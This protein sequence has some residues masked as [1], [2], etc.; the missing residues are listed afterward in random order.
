MIEQFITKIRRYEIRIRKAVNAD[1]RGSFRSV[2]KGSGVEFADL[3]E[4]QYGDDVRTIDWNVSAKGHGTFVK[5]FREEKEQTVFFILDVSGSQQVG[6]ANHSKLDTAKE[7]CGVLALSAIQEASH[8]GLLCFS[9][10]KEK[11]IHPSNGMKH[12]YELITELYKLK[13]TSTKTNLAESILF[14]LNVL[15][16]RSVVIFISD[17]I[18]KNYEHNL[19]ALARKHDLVM[20]HLLDKRETNLPRLGII[21]MVDPESNRTIWVNAS[22]P[23]F[24]KR[25][26]ED[27]AQV[28]KKIEQFARQ[29]DINYVAI[30][31]QQD[32]VEPLIKLFRIRRNK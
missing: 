20:V 23:W 14:T 2:F 24:R 9:D 28:G 25:V 19:R 10:Q 17:F 6:H 7:I 13:P 26:R 22:S 21:P 29:N 8:V 12:G 27:F 1:M 11:Y 18:D 4:Y 30:D 32:Y 31:S 15:K 5:I 3:R 16:R